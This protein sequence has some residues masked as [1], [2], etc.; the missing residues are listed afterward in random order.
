MLANSSVRYIQYATE[1]AVSIAS[2]DTSLT[3]RSLQNIWGGVITFVIRSYRHKSSIYVSTSGGGLVLWSWKKHDQ[4][5]QQIA[6]ASPKGTAIV[7]IAAAEFHNQAPEVVFAAEKTGSSS[8]VRAYIIDFSSRKSVQLL[9][10]KH[11][12]HSVKVHRSGRIILATTPNSLF[13]GY[14]AKRVLPSS[15]VESMDEL[16]YTWQEI[17]CKEPPTCF[18]FRF[19]RDP[20]LKINNQDVIL[21]VTARDRFDVA[22][23]GLKGCI[24][25]HTNLVSD[26]TT[27]A[28]N[29]RSH[30]HAL[31]QE[32]HWHRESVGAVAFSADGTFSEKCQESRKSLLTSLL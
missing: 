7:A 5:A 8:F 25:L 23:G 9:Q 27:P 16:Q 28:M 21:P 29:N 15:L 24:Y 30:K 31:P 12:I 3:E 11:Q 32:L 20:A 17:K 2:I 19:S 6:A 4:Q 13:V 22:Y 1:G 18:D 26:L 10:V 14:L